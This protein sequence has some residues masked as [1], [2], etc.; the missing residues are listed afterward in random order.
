MKA[1]QT[2]YAGIGS[3]QTP[4]HIL[5]AM[6]QLGKSL[7]EQGWVLRTG[8]CQGADQAFQRG[9]NTVNPK[10]VELFLPWSG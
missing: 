8:N 1:K 7:A 4:G 2:T 3:R 6:E 10:L 9:A 5:S